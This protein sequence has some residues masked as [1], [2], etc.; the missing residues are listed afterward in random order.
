M[1]KPVARIPHVV[2]FSAKTISHSSKN[3]FI[4]VFVYSLTVLNEIVV[5]QPFRIEDDC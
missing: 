3:L 5:D 4:H 2:P 1:E